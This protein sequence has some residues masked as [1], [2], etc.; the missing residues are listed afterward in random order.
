MEYNTGKRLAH[1]VSAEEAIAAVRPGD[2]VFVG[3]HEPKL[4]VDTLVNDK[5]R[6]T[7]L[8]MLVNVV[9]GDPSFLQP[10]VSK[11]FN[12]ASLNSRP[13]LG[14]S[15]SQGN[16]TYMPCHNSLLA[17]LASLK[18]YQSMVVFAHI[19]PPN[20]QG[21]C[22]FGTTMDYG[23]DFNDTAR[24][25]IAEVND[26]MPKTN[27]PVKIHVSNIDYI[28]RSSRPLDT[29]L[30]SKI[31]A[32]EQ[33]I[34][35]NIVSLIPDGA[36]IH[37]GIG[38]IPEAMC[39]CLLSRHD[40]GVHS[41]MFG[42]KLM[43]LVKSGVVT[44][45]YKAVDRGKCVAARI[46]GS[47]ELYR[48]V[49]ENPLVEVHPNRYISDPYVIGSIDNEVAVNSAISLDLTGQINSEMQDGILIGAVGAQVDFFR[50]AMR[51]KGGK[52]I[53]GI[54]STNR[55]G[56]STIVANLNAGSPVTTSRN[57][58][59]FVV[60][61]HGIAR[62]WGLNLRDRAKALI[63]IAHPDFRSELLKA[64]E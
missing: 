16:I 8:R 2:I 50:G 7:G 57:D 53:L 45:K 31:S 3:V 28:V 12:I 49:S 37:I 9:T 14:K 1:F 20:E 56:H 38:G 34:A 58:I 25:V 60:T 43:E 26:Q 61:E 32:A 4:L 11:H 29:L 17:R 55:N 22:S 54:R 23:W 63:S 18:E 6:L 40:L 39:G 35:E 51:S 13:K 19:G 15:L 52:A 30:P 21:Y 62:V 44:N 48:W 47:E 10:E 24:L 33:A 46:L 5:E 27:S 59:D 36:T 41:A 64:I 42:D